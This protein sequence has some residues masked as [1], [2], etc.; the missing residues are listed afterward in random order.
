MNIREKTKKVFVKDVQI[1]GQNK[2]VIQSMTTTKTH[3][4][5]AT[6]DQIKRLESLG[7]EIVRVAILTEKDALALK[8]IKK[9][10]NIPLVADIHF[11]YWYALLAI[12]YGADK[13]RFNP[14][15]IGS[16]TNLKKVVD[17][18]KEKKIPIRI[19]I[20]SG[21]LPKGVK[22]ESQ[23]PRGCCSLQY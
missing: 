4:I 13:I 7:C 17:A 6:V 1:G 10:I 21:S 2:I 14:G 9:Q 5:K 23:V 12:E 22:L 16:R 19:G 11:Q 8:E 15:N 3:D 18:A 20:N